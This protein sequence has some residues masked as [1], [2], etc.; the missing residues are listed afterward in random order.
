MR[1]WRRIDLTSGQRPALEENE[2]DIFVQDGVGIYEGRKKVAGHQN[3]RV[4]LTTHRVCYVDNNKP[5]IYSVAVNLAEVQRIQFYPGLLRSSAKVILFFALDSGSRTPISSNGSVSAP[6]SPHNNSLTSSSNFDPRASI[7]IRSSILP[8]TTWICPICSFANP[9]SAADAYKN[10]APPCKTCGI[11]PSLSVIE[12]AAQK[13]VAESSQAVKA[14]SDG[15]SCQRCTFVNHP[16]LMICEMCGE[17]LISKKIPSALIDSAMSDLLLDDRSFSPTPEISD[18][19][20]NVIRISFRHG[21]EKIFLEK[22]KVVLQDRMWDRHRIS[23]QKENI[24]DVGSRLPKLG[25]QGLE[26]Q[27][28]ME[29]E[30]NVELMKSLTDLESI[31]AKAKDLVVLAE[32]FAQRLSSLPGVPEEARNALLLSSEALSLSSPIVMREMSGKNDSAFHS[33]LSRQLVEF[34][35]GGVLAKEGGIITLFDLFALYNRARGISLVS[36]TD[37]YKAC[38]I[39]SR[40][41]LPY[42]LRRLSSGL[43]VIQQAYYSESAV[44]SIILKWIK[45]ES[46]PYQHEYFGVTAHDVNRKLGWSVRIALEELE[47]CEKLGILVRDTTAE[48]TRFYENL[49][50]KQLVTH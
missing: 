33:E 43:L 50:Q 11:A 22:L 41:R 29:N 31:M 36:P 4:Y 39:F 34:L 38:S 24:S 17:S 25:I 5:S 28:R 2:V 46:R 48:G 35:E 37:F 20:S 44:A 42:K 30:N 15:L 9:L 13:S 23:M 6:S 1:F 8:N 3:G 14:S 19:D 18:E 27:N 45:R 26:Q 40:L 47:T 21:G 12:D 7:N 32:T 16:A 10:V 49:F